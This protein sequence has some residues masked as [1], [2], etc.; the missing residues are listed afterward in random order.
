MY[1]GVVWPR[2]WLGPVGEYD[3]PTHREVGLA[4]I[5]GVVV[6]D[7]AHA[8][9]RDGRFSSGV[10]ATQRGRAAPTR[11]TGPPERSVAR[12]RVNAQR[13]TVGGYVVATPRG[14][15][16][17]RKPGATPAGVAGA[18]P[19][20]QPTAA[21]QR[22]VPTAMWPPPAPATRSMPLTATRLSPVG[23]HA[24]GRGWGYAAA[25]TYG[26]YRADGLTADAVCPQCL[27]RGQCPL[28]LRGRPGW[29]Y[30]AGSNAGYAAD[31]VY[32]YVASPGWGYTP[33]QAMVT[34]QIPT[35]A[36]LPP[37]GGVTQRRGS[38]A[39]QRNRVITTL[40]RPTRSLAITRFFVAGSALGPF[41][42][43]MPSWLSIAGRGLPTSREVKDLEVVRGRHS[44]S[45]IWYVLPQ[46]S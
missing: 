26:S 23:A 16:A 7:S 3:A 40:I 39:T 8:S 44:Q 29:G 11:I 5:L 43:W 12:S 37:W 4:V 15:A 6:V 1:G 35:P 14:Y 31:R 30:A 42:V 28:R 34:R 18:T 20:P 24:C 41:G 33:A 21:T 46:G 36:T 13:A 2:R 10:T 27:L 9:P 17:G 25:P 32:G 38:M 45:E 19:P 22:I